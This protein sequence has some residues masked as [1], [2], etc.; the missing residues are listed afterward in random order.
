MMPKM[1][2]GRD[3]VLAFSCKDVFHVSHPPKIKNK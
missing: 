2:V 1:K 3:A